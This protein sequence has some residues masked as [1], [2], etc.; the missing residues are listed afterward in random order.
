MLY[1]SSKQY[2]ARVTPMRGR[3][4][5]SLFIHYFPA[6]NNWNWTMCAASFVTHTHAPFLLEWLG[7]PPCS[8]YPCSASS[9]GGSVQNFLPPLCELSL[10]SLRIRHRWDVHT[11]V[12]P[13]FLNPKVDGGISFIVE[14]LTLFFS[15]LFK[16]KGASSIGDPFSQNASH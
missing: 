2:H 12:P 9:L 15:G 14:C 16:I 7:S 6:E 5:G 10:L 13:D 11:A 4:Y 1:E 8:A 3:H